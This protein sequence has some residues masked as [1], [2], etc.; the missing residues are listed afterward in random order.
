MSDT[1]SKCDGRTGQDTHSSSKLACACKVARVGW[2]FM[3]ELE[4]LHHWVHLSVKFLA[5]SIVF[6][7]FL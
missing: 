1:S 7:L 6:K 4:H 3:I 5:S 2:V